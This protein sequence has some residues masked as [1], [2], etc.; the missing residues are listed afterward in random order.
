MNEPRSISFP[1]VAIDH[2]LFESFNALGSQK[3]KQHSVSLFGN[4]ET[5]L[6]V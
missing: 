3:R 2:M 1:T 6:Q 5:S 4:M